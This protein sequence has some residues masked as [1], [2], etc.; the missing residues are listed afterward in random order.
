MD[1]SGQSCFP[2]IT[3]LEKVTSLSRP[4]IIK[5]LKQA[6]KDGWLIIEKHGYG[7]Q[8]WARNEYSASLPKKVVKEVN[9]KEK[10]S[11]RDLKGSKND[12]GRQLTSFKKVVK[13]VNPN[14][15]SNS[16]SNTSN[17]N[18]GKTDFSKQLKALQEKYSNE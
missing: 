11:K 12:N 1:S 15:S 7:G 13:E 9:H 14:S 16:S 2:S 17:N 8:K 4:T 5:Y 3:T 6:E 18:L 10:G